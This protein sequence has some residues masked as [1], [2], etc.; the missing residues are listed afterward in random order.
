MEWRWDPLEATTEVQ[1][2]NNSFEIIFHP[3]SSQG[4][5]AVRGNIPFVRGHIYYWEIEVIGST[6]A[7]DIVI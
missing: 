5:G 7:T 3:N 6:T 4:T 2:A 1:M